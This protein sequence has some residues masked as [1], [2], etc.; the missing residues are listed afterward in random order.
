MFPPTL[1]PGPFSF[2]EC[3][4]SEHRH[5]LSPLTSEMALFLELVLYWEARRF[6]SNLGSSSY[7]ERE[8]EREFRKDSFWLVTS[9]VDCLISQQS[10]FAHRITGFLPHHLV[11]N[12][13][14]HRCW[15]VCCQ[16]D[17]FL[18][19]EKLWATL[20]RLPLLLGFWG[21]IYQ[22]VTLIW[23]LEGGRGEANTLQKP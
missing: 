1:H 3:G 16:Q 19:P 21:K 23:H 9:L 18:L 15:I 20:H 11:F 4:P 6:P 13:C 22:G 5:P 12:W 7:W 2:P 14:F 8:R 10:P 17:H